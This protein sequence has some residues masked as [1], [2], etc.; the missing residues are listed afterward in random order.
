MYTVT[1]MYVEQ[2]Q[3]YI[4]YVKSYRTIVTYMYILC[5]YI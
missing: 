2:L 1:Y 3:F 4:R 5:D